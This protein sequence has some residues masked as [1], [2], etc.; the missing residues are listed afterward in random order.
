MSNDH[1]GGEACGDWIV[2]GANRGMGLEIA[3]ALAARSAGRVVLAVRDPDAGR[4]AVA[5]SGSENFE[6]RNLDLADRASVE[7][8]IQGWDRPLAGLV[9]NAGV[10]IIDGERFTGDGLELTFTVNHLHALRLTMGL[11]P[12]LRGGR[13]MFI[14]SGTQNPRH[15]VAPKFG[16]RGER[17]RSIRQC[18]DGIQRG[19]DHDR[20]GKD[21]YATSKFLNMVTTVELARR[22]PA[23]QTCFVCLDPGLMPG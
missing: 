23:E 12:W 17:Y 16:F 9:N 3:R 10:Q 5:A 11:L 1:Q 4:K 6:V 13:V 19:D 20:L 7:R 15:P 22:H 21:R 2:T 18:A 14:G 8:F